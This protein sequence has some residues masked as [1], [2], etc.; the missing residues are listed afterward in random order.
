[1]AGGFPEPRASTT[2]WALS[3]GL[4][5]QCVAPAPSGLGMLGLT[6]TLPGLAELA[7]QLDTPGLQL[8]DL[9]PG[10]GKRQR[11]QET[12]AAEQVRAGQEFR[13][14]QGRQDETEQSSSQE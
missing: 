9:R 6:Q 12:G 4:K 13:S 5:G 10:Q 11:D 7:L 8:P 14:G 3:G 2:R 1:M